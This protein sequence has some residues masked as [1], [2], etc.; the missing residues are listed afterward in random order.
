MQKIATKIFIVAS[1]AF[2]VTGI[3][4]VLTSSGPNQPDSE[5][6][7]TLMKLLLVLVF[8]ILPSFAVSVAGKYLRVK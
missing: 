3:L 7:D 8:I 5:V 1:I 2:G 4:M 6:T